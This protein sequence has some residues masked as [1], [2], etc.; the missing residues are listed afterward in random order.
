M[1]MQ[2]FGGQ[3]RCNMGDVHGSGDVYTINCALYITLHWHLY[4]GPV[5]TKKE[6]PR[7]I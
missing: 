2:N 7:H 1:L 4:C 3:T 5:D 6:R